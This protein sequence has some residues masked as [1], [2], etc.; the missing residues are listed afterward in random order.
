MAAGPR[1][2]LPALMSAP[3]RGVIGGVA[4]GT[5]IL[6]RQQ[7]QPAPRALMRDRM[8]TVL[9]V[10]RVRRGQLATGLADMEQR[11]TPPAIG[12]SALYQP[13]IGPAIRVLG[14]VVAGIWYG[15][16]SPGAVGGRIRAQGRERIPRS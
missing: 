12:G 5:P 14:I 3:H 9:A 11:G 8:M 15:R 1:A 7:A 13:R 10:D 4:A 16:R 6:D 2:T